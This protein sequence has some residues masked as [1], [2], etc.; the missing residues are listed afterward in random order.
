MPAFLTATLDESEWLG[1]RP[2]W[3][4]PEDTDPTPVG[5]EVGWEQ[6]RSGRFGEK[7]ISDPTGN[8][9]ELGMSS[10]LCLL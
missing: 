8:Q 3:F 7:K 6:I 9:T 10:V 1:S 5:Y 4:T 2:R